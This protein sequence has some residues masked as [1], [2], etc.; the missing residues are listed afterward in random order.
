MPLRVTRWARKKDRQENLQTLLQR[1]LSFTVI[2][3]QSQYA[4][5]CQLETRQR[6]LLAGRYVQPGKLKVVVELSAQRRSGEDEE[7][8]VRDDICQ[9]RGDGNRARKRRVARE[10]SAS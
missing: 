1:C 7:E 4:K 10:E 9:R 2:G 5:V 8:P 3:E 6:S